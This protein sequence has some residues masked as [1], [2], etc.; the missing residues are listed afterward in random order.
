MSA[1]PR[2][3][4]LRFPCRIGWSEMFSLDSSSE[5][6]FSDIHQIMEAMQNLDEDETI[7]YFKEIVASGDFSVETT[8]YV[9]E[10]IW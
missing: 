2:N 5:I 1:L 10:M 9:Y 7:I 8:N 4:L 6:D 3:G